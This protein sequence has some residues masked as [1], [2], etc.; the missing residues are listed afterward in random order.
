MVEQPLHKWEEEPDQ[1]ETESIRER[2]N[3]EELGVQQYTS[4]LLGDIC[5]FHFKNKATGIET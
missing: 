3:N 5:V 4:C 1:T 2:F